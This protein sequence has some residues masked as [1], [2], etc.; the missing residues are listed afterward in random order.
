MNAYKKDSIS[1]FHCLFE[2]AAINYKQVNCLQN[3]NEKVNEY[4]VKYYIAI[5]YRNGLKK[6][7]KHYQAT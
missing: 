5:F 4:H 3:R 6:I 1:P 2:F 7:K